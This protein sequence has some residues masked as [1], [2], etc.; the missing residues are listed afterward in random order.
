MLLCS[1]IGYLDRKAFLR[2]VTML[3]ELLSWLVLLPTAISCSKLVVQQEMA[4]RLSV[5]TSVHTRLH[6]AT[7]R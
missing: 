1:A 4:S 3:S 5:L 7:D 6:S 2:A